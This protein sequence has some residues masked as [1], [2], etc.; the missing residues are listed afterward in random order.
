MRTP[1]SCLSILAR[2]FALFLL[3]L[4]ILLL[5]ISM[6]ARSVER[7]LF[8]PDV[9]REAVYSATES[10][11]GTRSQL[12]ENLLDDLWMDMAGKDLPEGE[13]PFT[14]LTA[15]EYEQIADI[16]VPTD[17]FRTQVRLLIVDVVSWI[18]S[19]D[20]SPGFALE[21][22]SVRERLLEGGAHEVVEIVMR[23]WPACTPQ[24][25][26][27]IRNSLMKGEVSLPAFCL[28]PEGQREPWIMSMEDS[29]LGKV[30]KIP[31]RFPIGESAMDPEGIDALLRM[32]TNLRFLQAG[33][34]W[35]WVIPMLLMGLI[36][37]LAVRS[38]RD[39]GLWW[40]IPLLFSAIVLGALGAWIGRKGPDL[41]RTVLQEQ[42]LPARLYPP[43]QDAFHV[44][45]EALMGR[46]ILQLVFLLLIGGG[47]LIL[48]QW[49]T[50]NPQRR[51]LE[52]ARHSGAAVVNGGQ[53]G[54]S[55]SPD[56]PPPVTQPDFSRDQTL[57]P[58]QPEDSSTDGMFG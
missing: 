44:V 21:L 58:T 37:A 17:W 24:Q 39:L 52:Q 47:L 12:I 11:Q 5:P 16:I 36:V 10:S 25:A 1:T 57:A 32:R 34:R 15:R 3:L 18:E 14:H 56:G 20:P 50:R 28:M 33:M 43:M 42:E 26:E 38:W 4:L 49:F 2:I 40:G 27:F 19:E 31:D 13:T 46:M 23:T 6:L 45:Q 48:T 9:L 41:L 51:S 7:I 55:T 53:I 22:N 8:S 35:L 30:E 54:H 29:I